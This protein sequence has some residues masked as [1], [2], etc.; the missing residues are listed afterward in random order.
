M[1]LLQ[2]EELLEHTRNTIHEPTQQHKFN[3]DLTVSEIHLFDEA[4][5]MDFGGSEFDAAKTN[6]LPP[7]KKNPDD[8]YGWWDL[9]EGMYKVLF[10]E[11]LTNLQ[12]TLV[13]LAPHDHLRRSG[14]LGETILFASDD[15]LDRLSMNISVPHM[16]CKIKENARLASLYILAD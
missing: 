14:V 1:F 10:N 13:V 6:S 8:D 5:A 11:E 15:N 7:Q 3:L 4:G 2:S 16:G 12:D 9:E